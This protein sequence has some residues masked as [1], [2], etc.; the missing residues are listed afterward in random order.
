MPTALG[1]SVLFVVH[2]LVQVSVRIGSSNELWQEQ[3]WVWRVVND[4]QRRCRGVEDLASA[5]VLHPCDTCVLVFW[6]TEKQ[7]YRGPMK[8][9]VARR[10]RRQRRT[11]GSSQEVLKLIFELRDNPLSMQSTY[12]LHWICTVTK[13]QRRDS[14]DVAKNLWM[15]NGWVTYMEW[16]SVI[17]VTDQKV[18]RTQLWV[19]RSNL[20]W[21]QRKQEQ[22]QNGSI[23]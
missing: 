2:L 21:E 9:G 8:V 12:T 13:K 18:N 23:Q 16:R 4:R 20:T 10:H 15:T 7:S 5:Y 1:G 17:S 3:S 22:N 11:K 6:R 19:I 14:G